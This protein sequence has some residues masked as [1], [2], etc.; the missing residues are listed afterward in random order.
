MPSPA[1]LSDGQVAAVHTS[2]KLDFN[3]EVRVHTVVVCRISAKLTLAGEQ[4][5]GVSIQISGEV[6]VIGV[7]VVEA[8]IMSYY[9]CLEGGANGQLVYPLV[10]VYEHLRCA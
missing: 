5:V 10:V 3:S 8:G 2:R 4:D 1:E 9:V 6:A 7:I